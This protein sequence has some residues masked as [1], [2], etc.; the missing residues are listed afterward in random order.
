MTTRKE[1]LDM[2]AAGQ[3][4]VDE[5]ADRL[6][7]LKQAPAAETVAEEPA[8]VEPDPRPTSSAAAED[9]FEAELSDPA[10]HPTAMVTKSTGA[11]RGGQRWLHIQV[12]DLASGE[13]RVRVNVPVG[14]IRL[15][16]K[17]GAQFTDEVNHDVISDV[18]RMIDDHELT[19]TLVEVEDIES[20]EHVHIYI[21]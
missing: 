21:D 5:A 9:E 15:G 14:L 17:V 1:I 20:N 7:T 3:L 18:I 6:N 4:D 16:L 12:G 13:S 11:R 2:L 10:P 19:G 8:T